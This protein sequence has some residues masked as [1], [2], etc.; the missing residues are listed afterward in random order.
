MTFRDDRDA[1]LARAEALDR[2]VKRLEEEN[3]ELRAAR[4]RLAARSAEENEELAEQRARREK[5]EKLAASARTEKRTQAAPKP[6]G[7]L[8]EYQRKRRHHLRLA[9]TGFWTTFAFA[10][11]LLF[12][13]VAT[14]IGGAQL[15]HAIGAPPIVLLLFPI[16]ML[17]IL[18]VW[19][20]YLV[21]QDGSVRRAERWVASLPLHIDSAAYCEHMATKFGAMTIELDVPDAGDDKELI[22]KAVAGGAAGTSANWNGDT[23]VIKCPALKTYFRAKGGGYTSNA[24]THRWFRRFARRVLVPIADTHPVRATRILG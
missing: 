21:V 15:L 12:V 2:D 20:L 7:K 24:K 19:G 3:A 17:A 8:S 18:A 1:T 11:L 10:W 14:Y 16:F 22:R 9:F 4:E 23:L 13:M 5:L 6:R